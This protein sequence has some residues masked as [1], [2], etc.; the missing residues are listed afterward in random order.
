MKFKEYVELSE[1]ATFEEHTNVKECC[2]SPRT[3]LP[4][5]SDGKGF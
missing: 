2:R 1:L 5:N 4:L 3:Q